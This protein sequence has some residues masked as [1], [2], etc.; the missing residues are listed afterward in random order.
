VS[1]QQR[2]FADRREAG[3]RLADRLA[4]H[5]GEDVVVLG[6]PR[7][8]VPVAA[9]VADRLG[10]ELDVLVVRKLGLPGRPELAMGAVAAVG[11]AV[12]TVRNRFVI[13]RA[14]VDEATFE[15]VR[16]REVAELQRRAAAFRRES[17]AVPVRGR[18]VVVTDDG[19]ATGSTMRAAVAALREQQ[20]RR[21][22]VAVPVGSRSAVEQ[23]TRE[24][25]EVVC[26][27]TPEPFSAVG[28]G[29]LDFAPTADD[30]VRNALSAA[31]RRTRGPARD[32]G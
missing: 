24:V 18:V 23:L 9:E 30:E 15:E 10:A 25:D 19:L 22:V 31:G 8:G 32:P 26:V 11:D 1:G 4:R 28:Q 6:L 14:H 20:P 7:G 27:W 5:A 13:E 29:Y 12:Q 16:R 21:V 2:P 3:R 17:P